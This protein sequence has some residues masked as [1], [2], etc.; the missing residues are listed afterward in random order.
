M[1]A[2]NLIN[3]HTKFGK[4]RINTF[5]CN[6]RKLDG[7]RQAPEKA[8]LICTPTQWGGQNKIY[9]LLSLAVLI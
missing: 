2:I 4:D 6:D 1:Q 3:T 8:K 5:P 9:A 7:G